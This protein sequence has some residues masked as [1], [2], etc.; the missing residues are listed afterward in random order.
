MKVLG[1]TSE[2]LVSNSEW[3]LVQIRLLIITL[4]HCREI[5][6]AATRDA[7]ATVP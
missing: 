6:T 1:N 7:N 3:I 2:R 5:G 4:C